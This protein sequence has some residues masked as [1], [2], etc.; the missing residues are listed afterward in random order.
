MPARNL[1][2]HIQNLLQTDRGKQHNI[3]VFVVVLGAGQEPAPAHSEPAADRPWKQ[4]NI[5][6]FVVLGVCLE[7]ALA[8]SEP[9]A[10]RP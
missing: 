8:H 5:H 7:P 4:H 6:V 1:H 2:Q 10:D 3:H 9:E